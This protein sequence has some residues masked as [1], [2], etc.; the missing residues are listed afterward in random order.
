[1]KVFLIGACGVIGRSA[2]TALLH[3][4]H[5][6]VGL[7]RSRDAARC[8]D[9]EVRRG[10]ERD[11]IALA[12]TMQDCDVV[13]NLGP[14]QPVGH[15]AALPGAWRAH[16]LAHG[17]GSARVAGAAAQVGVPRLVQVSTSALY[18]GA[19]DDWVDEHSTIDLTQTSEPA[20]LAEANAEAFGREGGDHVVLRLGRLSGPVP[21]SR[22]MVRRARS[23]R[24]TGFGDP[25][26]WIHLLHVDDAG[27]AIVAALTAPP[28]TYNVGA[29]PARR[30]D[31]TEQYAIAGD[32]RG[33]RFHSRLVQRLGGQRL[34]ML[35]RSQR[36]SSQR[37]S[38]RTGWYPLYPKLTPD[39]F[40][41]VR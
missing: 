9:V 30:Q 38:D 34:E 29:E 21:H 10:S 7:S 5:A 31:L 39:W 2:T 8:P 20:V 23:G 32:R 24:P 4:G 19:G 15:V 16:D 40:D 3:D 22:W 35:T 6:V 26:S 28:G 12:A 17:I 11:R 36:V 33:G 13:V 37:F 41:D 25:S 14:E 18:A 1:M 27:A